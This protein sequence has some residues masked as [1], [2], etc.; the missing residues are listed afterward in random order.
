VGKE[1]D[2]QVVSGAPDQ[3]IS[4]IDKLEIVFANGIAYDPQLLLS[5]VKGLVGGGEPAIPL[6]RAILSEYVMPSCCR[7]ADLAL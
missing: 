4:D 7:P 1:A 3:D 6:E 2:L 5:R